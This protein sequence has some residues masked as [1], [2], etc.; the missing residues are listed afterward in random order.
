MVRLLMAGDWLELYG[1]QDFGGITGAPL[2]DEQLA[3]LIQ[4]TPEWSNLPSD[5]K[6]I[7]YAAQNFQENVA[8]RYNT[9]YV[10]GGGH[11]SLKKIE[12]IGAGDT[13]DCSSYVCTILY[14]A[15]LYQGECLS[16]S[17]FASSRYFQAI[18]YSQLKP[19]DILVKGGK[20]VVLYLGGNKIAHASTS[21]KPLK[22]TYNVEGLQYYI[23]QG[24]TAMRPTFVREN[25][26]DTD[27]TETDTDYND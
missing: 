13:F 9:R 22:D 1:I 25:V 20:H 5:R 15:G 14:N 2:T 3:Q 18:S 10:Y 24:F 17:G 4:N 8:K 23:N 26:Y 7:V 16:T 12:Q 27:N 21:S 19:G 11:G 6:S